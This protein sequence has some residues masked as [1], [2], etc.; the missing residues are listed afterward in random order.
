VLDSEKH[1]VS[2][3][4]TQV[5][6]LPQDFALLEHFMR[7]PGQVFTTDALIKRVWSTD[8][9]ATSD[10]VRSSIKRIRQKL[11]D[12]SDEE[13]SIIETNRRVGYRLRM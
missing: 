11:D 8:S 6:L 10:S 2:K 9:E 12:Q 1:T 7:H 13:N 5:H 4:G 3:D